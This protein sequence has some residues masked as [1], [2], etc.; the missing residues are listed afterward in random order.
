MLLDELLDEPPHADKNVSENNRVNKRGDLICF[1]FIFIVHLFH[2][3][4]AVDLST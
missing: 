4:R 1:L 3:M 2:L